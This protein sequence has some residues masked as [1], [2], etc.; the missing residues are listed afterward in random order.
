LINVKLSKL[1]RCRCLSA[2]VRYHNCRVQSF[3]A[4]VVRSSDPKFHFTNRCLAP[5]ATFHSKVPFIS[6]SHLKHLD[7][8][9]TP[10]PGTTKME[11]LAQAENIA[12]QRLR[13]TFKYPT[14]SD[15][16]DAIEAGMDEQGLSTSPFLSPSPSPPNS[17]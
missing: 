8:H 11:K 1:S 16:E 10:P 2:S 17:Y 9:T 4:N 14:E 7:T 13:K 5:E 6:W 15:D 12:A 3:P